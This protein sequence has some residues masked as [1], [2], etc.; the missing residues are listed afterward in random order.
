V[1][2]YLPLSAG[3]SAQLTGTLYGQGL[4][5]Q[6]SIYVSG[7]TYNSPNDISNFNQQGLSGLG[8]RR[9]GIVF[10][11]ADSFL[12]TVWTEYLGN[13]APWNGASGADYTLSRCDANATIVTPPAINI[14]RA[15]GITTLGG[16]LILNADATA[17]LGA[18]TLQQVPA[19]STTTP[20][21]LG[22]AAVGTGT[23]WARADHVHSTPTLGYANL[24][25]EVQQLQ[26]TFA[27]SGKP[28]AAA[29]IFIPTVMSIS[30]PAA[31]AGSVGYVNTPPAASAVFS[32][33]TIVL[34]VIG[35]ITVATSGVVTFTGAG[36]V[37]GI[38][39]SDVLYMVAPTTQDTAMLDVGI[40]I[41]ALR[42]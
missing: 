20:A 4:R 41:L 35:T 29:Y 6:G 34:G 37:G 33:A 19:A 15:T 27:F 42:D 13:N 26:F 7:G 24:P 38:N 8:N 14:E 1:S 28:A 11:S 32:L 18:A 23:T 10:T 2:G 30:I 36:A 17:P 9:Q 12:H 16:P 25:A 3:S 22:T 31:L 40:T 21:P 39:A 5:A